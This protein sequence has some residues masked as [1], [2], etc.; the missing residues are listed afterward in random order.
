MSRFSDVLREQLMKSRC[1]I[2]HRQF[3]FIGNSYDKQQVR[4]GI[5]PQ[6]I[7]NLD[8]PFCAAAT[9]SKCGLCCIICGG[10]KVCIIYSV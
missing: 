5:H 2:C 9:N 3:C 6:D 8:K 7:L 10:Y 4:I 1:H